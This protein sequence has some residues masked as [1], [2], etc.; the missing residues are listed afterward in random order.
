MMF[1]Q[2]FVWGAWYVTLGTWLATRLN[3][4]GEQIGWTMGS[5]AIGAILSPFFVGLIADRWFATQKMLATLHL[6][7]AG[8]LI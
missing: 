2:Y 1:L 4:T 6:I 3:F 7:G 8:L 5:T